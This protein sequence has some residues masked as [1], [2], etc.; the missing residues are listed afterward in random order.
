MNSFIDEVFDELVHSFDV[1]EFVGSF[2]DEPGRCP[3]P[4]VFSLCWI[5]AGEKR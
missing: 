2:I 5:G 1:V 4:C 3:W